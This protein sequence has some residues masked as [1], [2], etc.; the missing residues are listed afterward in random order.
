M[1]FNFFKKKQ[2]TPPPTNGET[3][4]MREIRLNM[5]EFFKSGEQYPIDTFI[6]MAGT[7]QKAPMYQFSWRWMYNTTYNSDLL[8]TIVQTITEESMKNGIVIKEKYTSKCPSCGREFDEDIP[9]C[10]YDYTPTIKPDYNE[11]KIIRDFL[12]KTNSF[13]EDFLDVMKIV[14][15]DV[16]IGD[17]GWILIVKEYIYNANKDLV[18]AKVKEIIR[19]SPMKMRLIMS[20]Y[21]MGI[22]DDGQ[23]MYFCPEHRTEAHK[24]DREGKY[25]CPKCGREMLKAWFSAKDKSQ[26]YYYSPSEVYHI[27]KW[28]NVSGYGVPPLYSVWMKVLTLMKMDRFILEAY[29]LQ[30][31]PKALLILRAKLDS[32]RK[33]WEWLMQKAREN[34]NMI[35]PLVLEGEES[36]SRRIVDYVQFDLKPEEW[37]WL[38]M[39]KEFRETVGLVYGVQPIFVEGKQGSGLQNEGLM[40]AVTNRTIGRTQE[41]WNRFLQW[42]CEK[43]LGVDSYTMEL[44]PTEVEDKIRDLDIELKRIQEAQML[45]Q[46]GYNVEI[47]RDN[48]DELNFRF[49]KE[50][51]KH[52]ETENTPEK[53]ELGGLSEDEW[54]RINRELSGDTK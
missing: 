34:P 25:H 48:K 21:G 13:D 43:I 46:L 19:L 14:D 42:F 45:Y 11:Y 31:S 20:N 53:R 26:D 22:S 30:R 37:Q 28:S 3:N 10:P 16:N 52:G 40:I 29:S 1:A 27:K 4:G 44:V 32:F 33:A 36:G 15:N 54:K 23:Y 7:E 51:I 38:E 17:N 39:R 24:F 35:Y 49:K 12:E 2:P 50:T 5:D 6:Q 9:V 8:R 47:Y 41:V 18:G